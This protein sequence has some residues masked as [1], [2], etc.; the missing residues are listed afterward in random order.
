M[1][2][3]RPAT[4]TPIA[5]AR[6]R[7]TPTHSGS[8]ASWTAAFPTPRSLERATF[9]AACMRVSF[10]TITVMVAPEMVSTS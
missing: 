10:C 9:R 8:F 4:S 6:S 5:N 1:R 2:S 3:A 7:H